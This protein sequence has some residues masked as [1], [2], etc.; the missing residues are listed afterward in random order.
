MN[1]ATEYHVKQ[2][3]SDECFYHY[4]VH[5]DARNQVPPKAVALLKSAGFS[6]TR[7][8]VNCLTFAGGIGPNSQLSEKMFE[9]T[10]PDTWTLKTNVATAYRSGYGV[11]CKVMRR[12]GIEG[13][14]ES[15]TVHTDR[16][17]IG[18][19]KPFEAELFDRFCPP[20]KGSEGEQ[21]TFVD[22]D[23][24]LRKVP[25][26]AQQRQLSAQAGERAPVMEFHLSINYDMLANHN[27]AK[28]LHAMGLVSYEVP[29]ICAFPSGEIV[30]NLDGTP[31]VI[32]ERPL[33][34]RLANPSLRARLNGSW[35]KSIR[36][37]LETAKLFADLV[38]TL[39]GFE[40]PT[41]YRGRHHLFPV[42]F[43]L[44][45]LSGFSYTTKDYS[46]LPPVL[47]AV[48]SGS[49]TLHP[50]PDTCS[51]RSLSSYLE[52]LWLLHAHLNEG[53]KKL[54]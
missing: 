53:T 32:H 54:G 10:E 22:V 12:F 18:A 14:V 35:I 47:G 27:I 6:R 13:Y 26:V 28:L 15:E 36:R 39:G 25:F 33:T 24:V 38:N 8:A 52:R 37:F 23:N 34:L 46:Q 21:G 48:H 1:P 2:L 50:S 11:A 49:M 3:T 40:L 7:V 30:R 19:S 4:H 41:S 20:V 31:M 51:V 16:P 5:L 45:S 17:L 9:G 44:E 42:T 29:K 43:K